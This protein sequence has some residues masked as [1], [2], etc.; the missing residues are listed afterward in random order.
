MLLS[1]ACCRGDSGE[2]MRRG[3]EEG[4]REGAARQTVNGGLASVLRVCF[5][6]RH[7]AATQELE[8]EKESKSQMIELE[9][10]RKEVEES[11]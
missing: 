4:E 1:V 6:A 11:A 9:Q 10:S 3:G 7:K 2:A 5:L 8:V